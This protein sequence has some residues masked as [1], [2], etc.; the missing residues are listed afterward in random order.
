MKKSVLII[1]DDLDIADKL[2]DL[3]ELE[4]FTAQIATDGRMAL[5]QLTAA[6]NKPSV[7]LLDIMM[8]IMDGLEFCQE[9][10]EIA[11]LAKIPVVVMTA[12]GNSEEKVKQLRVHAYLKKPLDVD[13]L[14][15]TLAN[16][17]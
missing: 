17:E 13:L 3:L 1:E 4:G 5:N 14:I 6:T 8:P 16:L 7:I 10:C 2:K 9:Q 11:E 15:S 12:G